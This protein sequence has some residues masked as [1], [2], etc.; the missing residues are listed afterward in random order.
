M[1]TLQT[2][3][4]MLILS[5]LLTLSWSHFGFAQGMKRTGSS[6]FGFRLNYVED[7]T[8]SGPNGSYLKIDG[9]MGFGFNYMYNTS[10][11]WSFGGSFDWVN[12]DYRAHA[13][14]EDPADDPFEYRNRMYNYSLNFDTIYH[15]FDSNVTPY[16]TGS[17]GW[18]SIDTNVAT[19]P[20]Y[21]YCWWD[22]WGYYCS[23]VVPTK[24]KNG[25]N[26]KVGA[27]MRWDVN[28]SFTVRGSVSYSELDINIAGQNPENTIWRIELV[29]RM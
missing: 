22:W 8:Y 24:R 23:T 27:G 17:L 11:H 21:E 26:Y 19:G 9:D 5:A 4:G 2:S 14:P 15:L 10:E 16:V 20:G 7:E 3:T 29:S 12:L 6:E 13:E 25:F 28:R 18:T 1:Q